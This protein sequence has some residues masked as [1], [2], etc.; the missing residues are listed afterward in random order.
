MA[1]RTL[2]DSIQLEKELVEAIKQNTRKHGGTIFKKLLMS[3]AVPY[4]VFIV[5]WVIT[6]E[7]RNMVAI[8][9]DDT[10]LNTTSL[11]SSILLVVMVTIVVWRWLEKRFH[12]VALIGQLVGISKAVLVVEKKIE[13][14]KQKTEAAP[15]DV[16]EIERLAYAAWDQYTQV[17]RDAGLPVD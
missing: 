3:F 2:Q 11:I 1:V 6:S 12:G 14:T 15:S 9:Y 10:T 4:V 16:A 5:L 7:I 17:M 13:E 8:Q